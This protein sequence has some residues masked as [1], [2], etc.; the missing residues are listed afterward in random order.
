M[1]LYFREIVKGELVKNKCKHSKSQNIFIRVD[2]KLKHD[3][4][5]NISAGRFETRGRSYE[6]RSSG[7][8]FVNDS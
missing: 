6:R 1:F 5:E 8:Q 2:N 3:K 7:R 4:A